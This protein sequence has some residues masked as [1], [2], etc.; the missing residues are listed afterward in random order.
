M[1]MRKPHLQPRLNNGFTEAWAEAW[2]GAE[3][4]YGHVLLPSGSSGGRISE[5]YTPA[6]LTKRVCRWF[7]HLPFSSEVRHL[8][9]LGSIVVIA[10]L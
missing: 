2:E 5:S 7:L 4:G 8:L 6:R 1:E 10:H 9:V 3:N